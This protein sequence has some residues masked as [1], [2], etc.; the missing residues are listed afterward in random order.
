MEGATRP[1][2]GS[3]DVDVCRKHQV[4]SDF[5]HC[6]HPNKKKQTYI[7]NLLHNFPGHRTRKTNAEKCFTVHTFYSC[8]C[9]F[10]DLMAYLP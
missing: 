7:K 3:P 9:R 10:R 8:R 5:G 1:A 6:V 2:A 4:N